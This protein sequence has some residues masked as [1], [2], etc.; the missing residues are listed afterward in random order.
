[1]A[2]KKRRKRR[3][4][5]K[6]IKLR[7]RNETVNSIVGV[8][9]LLLGVLII[10][11]FSGQGEF[12]RSLNKMMSDKV[13]IAVLFAP[14]VFISAGLVMFQAKWAWTKPHVLLGT[15]LLMLATT[16]I[17]KSGEVGEQ[18]FSNLA[19]LIS[20]IGAY[21]SFACLFLIGVLVML[22]STLVELIEPLFKL[23]KTARDKEMSKIKKESEKVNKEVKKARG[24]VIPKLSFNFKKKDKIR[25]NDAVAGVQAIGDD[26]TGTAVVTEQKDVQPEAGFTDSLSESGLTS[27]TMPVVWEYPPLSL[28][29]SKGGGKADRGDVKANAQIIENTLESFG[30]KAKVAEVNYGP[31]VTQYALEIA[32]GTRLSK[33]TSLSTDLALALA[34]PTGQIRIEAPIV[35]RSLVGV[36]VPNYSAQFVTLK[37]MLGSSKMKKHSSKLAV[38]LGIDVAGKPIIADIAKMPHLLIAGA[39]GSGKSVA[40][41]SFLCSMLFRASP[42]EVKLILVDPKRV[43]LTGYNGIPHLLT[44]VIVEPSKVISALKWAVNLM[45][46]RYKQ[47]AEVG[48]RNISA[49]NELAG[50]AA[51]PNIVIVIDELADIMLFAPGEVEESVT[52]IAQMARA[53]GIHL[54]LATQRPSVDVITGLIKANIS[55]RIA[56]NVSSMMDSRVILDTPGAEKLLG[57]GDMLYIPPDQ[58]KPSRIQGTFVADSEIKNLIDFIKSQG[59]KPQYEEDIT[60]KFKAS[61]IKGGSGGAGGGKHDEKFNEAVRLFAKYDKASSSLIPRRLSVGYARAARILDQLYEAGFVGAPEGSKPRVVHM[62]K[63]QGYLSSLQNVE[64]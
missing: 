31:S 54:V 63:V 38:A 6:A 28:L 23:K 11:S 40:V 15:V 10:I 49:Y 60:T 43:E 24:F 44:P 55:T 62:A 53:V 59:Q 33:I 3:T 18:I 29:S 61:I 47:L 42:S 20:S 13:G 30:I 21:V 35:G 1:M 7:V 48:V 2:K 14:F 56:F 8:F 32:R 46:K 64:N 5:N 36:E 25:V 12:L 16:S 4:K 51:M 22:Q 50:I 37:T 52:R 41:N 17:L 39:T 26:Q 9:F 19:K 57:R 34:A 27:T 45:E 58:A